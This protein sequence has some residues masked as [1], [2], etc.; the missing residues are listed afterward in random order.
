MKENRREFMKKSCRALSMTALATQ[1]RHFGLMNV[2]AQEKMAAGE[3]MAANE[4]SAVDYK[5]MVCVFLSGGNDSNN[6]IIP[7][8]TEGYNQYA[9]AR[10]AQGLA[11]PQASLL[12]ITPPSMG[13][14]VYGLHPSMTDLHT[15]WNQGKM[16][17]VC[18]VGSLVNPMTRAQY[19]AG[20]VPKPYQLFSHSDQVEQFRTAVSSSKF[21]D[22]LPTAPAG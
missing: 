8:Y 17:A 7:N 18:N 2:I 6:V 22:A 5:A 3:K 12:P 20:T 10:Q 1:M 9:A 16:A 13:G 15:L 21:L 14:Q 19:Q 4:D 11:L